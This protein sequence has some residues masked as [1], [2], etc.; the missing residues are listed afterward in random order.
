MHSDGIGA[1]DTGELHRHDGQCVG[2][3]HEEVGHRIPIL[4][5]VVAVAVDFA[6]H[7]GHVVHRLVGLHHAEACR[8]DHGAARR[9]GGVVAPI[10]DEHLAVSERHH[11]LR[12]AADL[13]GCRVGKAAQVDDVQFVVV[14]VVHLLVADVGAG[15]KQFAALNCHTFGIELAKDAGGLYFARG[16][17]D[18]HHAVRRIAADIEFAAVGSDI[19]RGAAAHIDAGAGTGGGVDYL[20]AV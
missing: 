7:N 10:V 14:A 15:H 2:I 6:A 9:I 19:A 3:H 11:F 4:V 1:A 16:R 8:I 5:I 12:V 18:A 13:D 17:V 20:D